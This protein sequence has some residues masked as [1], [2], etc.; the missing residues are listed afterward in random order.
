M[1]VKEQL[2][3]TTPDYNKRFYNSRDQL[4]EIR[5]STSYTGATDTT[6]GRGAIVNS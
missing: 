1:M 4:A 5:A 6:S 2:G 3:A